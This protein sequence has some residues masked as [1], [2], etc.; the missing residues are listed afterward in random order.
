MQRGMLQITLRH[1]SL[2]HLFQDGLLPAVLDGG[3]NHLL[4]REANAVG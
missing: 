1:P 4:W 3:K 2:L